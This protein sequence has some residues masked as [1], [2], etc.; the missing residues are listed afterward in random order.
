MKDSV[1]FNGIEIVIHFITTQMELMI[2]EGVD[3]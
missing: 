2:I 1:Q 3:H